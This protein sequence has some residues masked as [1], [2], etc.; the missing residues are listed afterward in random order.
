MT[1]Y[2]IQL[3]YL[4]THFCGW[5]KQP[6]DKGVQETLENALSTI[7]GESI[8]CTGCGRTDTGVHAR[9]YIAHFSY[10]G[11]FPPRFLGR[12]NR[13]IGADISIHGIFPMHETAH[14][15]FD[16]TRRTYQYHLLF[17]KD[18]FRTHT[19]YYYGD[20]NRLHLELMQ[21]ASLLLMQYDAFFPFC[22]SD[23][24]AGTMLCQLSECHW[25]Y[26]SQTDELILTISSNRFL[27]GMVRLIVGMCIQVGEGKLSLQTVK[28]VMET[29]TRLAKSLSAPPQGLFLNHIQYPY[30]FGES[31]E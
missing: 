31:I 18:P 6:H 16:A 3:S 2:F 19:A 5:Q 30:P 8:E 17:E 22:K 27:R 12:L 15:R 10:G 28:E 11:E 26:E 1:R 13:F 21:E 23:N 4:G 29:Q 14:A 9:N 25:R 24:D 7:L 20:K